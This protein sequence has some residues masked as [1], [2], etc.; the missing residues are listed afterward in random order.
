V[1]ENTNSIWA[2][3]AK[4]YLQTVVDIIT[5]II[6]SSDNGTLLQVNSTNTDTL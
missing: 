6:Y 3:N 1:K 4:F 2:S 5:S